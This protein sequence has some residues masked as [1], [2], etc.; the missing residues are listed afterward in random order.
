[1]EESLGA[2][3]THEGRGKVAYV[4]RVC[5]DA[6][7]VRYGWESTV[8]LGL[9]GRNLTLIFEIHIPKSYILKKEKIFEFFS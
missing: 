7:S 2:T 1:M 9:Y 8:N 3:R 4:K 6:C 5:G